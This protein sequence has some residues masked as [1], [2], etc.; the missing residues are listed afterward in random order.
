MHNDA[1][2]GIYRLDL[3]G[4]TAQ[5]SYSIAPEYRRRGYGQEMLRA[6]EALAGE[7]FPQAKRLC[8]RVKPGNEAS[9]ALFGRL[10][11]EERTEAGSLVYEKNLTAVLQET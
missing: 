6:G 5:I 7:I 8:A 11:Y 3:S 9:R 10:G 1:P 4:E 2:V